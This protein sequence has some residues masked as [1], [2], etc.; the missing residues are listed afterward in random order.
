MDQ[1]PDSCGTDNLTIDHYWSNRMN[2][3]SIH[4]SES[5]QV[6]N[7]SRPCF[8]E[9]KV[10]PDKDLCDLE[11]IMKHRFG[12]LIARHS[13]QFRREFQK[14]D[15]VNACRLESRQFFF[16]T[17]QESKIDVRSQ[18]LDRMGMKRQNKRGSLRLSRRFDHGLQQC[19]MTTMV[20]IEVPDRSH[21]MRSGPDI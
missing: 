6:R 9:G 19:A 21:G 7:P 11:P 17:G 15:F 8:S 12:E 3:K 4:R 18:H 13:C 14:H 1:V 16:R 10:F 5:R 2:R 20:P